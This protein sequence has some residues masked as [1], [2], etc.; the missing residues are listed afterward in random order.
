MKRRYYWKVLGFCRIFVHHTIVTLIKW[1][2]CKKKCKNE[3]YQKWPKFSIT[4]RWPFGGLFGFDGAGGGGGGKDLETDTEFL[5]D[6]EAASPETLDK[7]G[8]LYLLNTR[9][10]VYHCNIC[11]PFVYH[12][13]CLLTNPTMAAT[14]HI[15]MRTVSQQWKYFT[16]FGVSHI[17]WWLLS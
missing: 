13:C 14:G 4:T 16:L 12:N 1:F 3:F 8:H 9:D 2:F 10:N 5:F 17:P 11:K 7:E 6:V 15:Q